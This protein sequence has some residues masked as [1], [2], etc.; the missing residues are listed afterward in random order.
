MNDQTL[1][2]ACPALDQRVWVW[3]VPVAPVTTSQVL[4]EVDRLIQVGAPSYFLSA[5]L[6]YAMLTDRHAELDAINDQAAFVLADGM[7]LL[8]SARWQGRRLPERV[9][10]SDLIFTLSERAAQRGHRVFLYGGGPGVAE[11]AARRLVERF[12]NLQVVGTLTPP[13]KET[14]SA[15]EMATIRE[16]IQAAR[17]DLLMVA[18]SQPKGER[19][20]H[21]YYQE[22]GVPVCTQVGAAIDFATGRIA[23]APRW[24]QVSGLEWV[25]RFLLEPRR[26]GGRYL[27]NALFLLRSILTGRISGRPGDRSSAASR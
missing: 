24:M 20:I 21:A 23:R 8:W 6:N 13:Y 16:A 18:L 14:L 1:A 4:D 12:P 27:S 15:E 19:W 22:L 5:N 2:E 26:L 17:P 3:G 7:P 9:A 10:G 25:F 11:V